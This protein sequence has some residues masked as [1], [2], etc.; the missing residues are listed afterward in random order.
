MPAWGKTT[1]KT[2]ENRDNII[3]TKSPQDAGMNLFAT[4]GLGFN[5]KIWRRFTG[6]AEVL[7]IKSNL[8]GDNSKYYNWQGEAPKHIQLISSFGL[9]FNYNF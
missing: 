6:Y 2:I 9:G 3:T 4:A 7:L 8:S 1:L 5:Y